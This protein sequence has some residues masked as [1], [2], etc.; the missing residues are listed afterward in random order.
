MKNPSKNTTPVALAFG[1]FVLCVLAVL[2]AGCLAVL[3]D[4][5]VDI[6]RPRTPVKTSAH[7]TSGPKTSHKS[8][9][10][11][12]TTPRRSSGKRH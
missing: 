2:L 10:S 4:D 3:D 6:D 8:D 12:K 7:K 9:K 1:C 5:D 11:R